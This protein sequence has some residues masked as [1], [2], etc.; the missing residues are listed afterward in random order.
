MP[1]PS[2]TYDSLTDLSLGQIPQVEDDELYRELLDLHN[3]IESLL[4]SSDS[5]DAIFLAFINKFRNFTEV[6]A[7]YTVLITDGT[8]RVDASLGDITITLHPIAEGSGYRYGVKRVDT[9][10]A[11]NVTLIDDGGEPVDGH[12]AGINISTLSSYTVK[13]NSTG[14]DII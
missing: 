2:N 5:A 10:T 7:D 3:A 8:L 9:V 12:T 13:S 4:S 1:A 6:S 11:N 14:W